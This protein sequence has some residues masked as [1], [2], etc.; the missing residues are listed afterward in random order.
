MAAIIGVSDYFL[1]SKARFS[2]LCEKLLGKLSNLSLYIRSFLDAPL[3]AEEAPKTADSFYEVAKELRAAGVFSACG[4]KEFVFY[5]AGLEFYRAQ[6][7]NV[8]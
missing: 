1:Y 4:T 3:L 8:Q 2:G 7:P 6:V 5:W